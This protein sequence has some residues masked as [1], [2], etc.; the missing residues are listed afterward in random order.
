MASATNRTTGNSSKN[1]KTTNASK[2]QPSC[3]RTKALMGSVLVRVAPN[4]DVVRKG[5]L[6]AGTSNNRVA[7]EH[8]NVASK[9]V[10]AQCAN[11]A[12]QRQQIILCLGVRSPHTCAKPQF[13]HSV[14]IR[15]DGSTKLSSPAKFA[16]DAAGMSLIGGG[17]LTLSRQTPIHSFNNTTHKRRST[18]IS[19]HR[20][21][22]H[23][24]RIRRSAY[25]SPAARGVRVFQ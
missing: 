24:F 20:V 10:P 1:R 21:D 17:I 4:T 23:Y 18:L 15:V 7:M 13:G 16:G 5:S 22:R 3:H 9:L 11:T 6:I 8:A 14:V 19:G 12:R 2:G 25:R